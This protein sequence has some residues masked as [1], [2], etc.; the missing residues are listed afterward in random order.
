MGPNPRGVR[1][2]NRTQRPHL[3]TREHAAEIARRVGLA[4]DDAT[5]DALARRMRLA[6]SP[7]AARALGEMNA[8]IDVRPVLPSVQVPTLVLYSPER[9]ESGV[10]RR[11]PNAER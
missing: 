1:P 4:Q 8:E 5:L 9:E 7:G 11:G 6:A 2:P 3:G 10:V